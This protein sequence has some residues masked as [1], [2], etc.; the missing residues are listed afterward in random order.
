MAF[1]KKVSKIERCSGLSDKEFYNKYVKKSVPVVVTD[2]ATWA[3][4]EKFTPKFFK[5]NYG[6]LKRTIDGKTY[7]LSEIIDLCMASTPENKAPYPNI[8]DLNQ[9]F[10]EFV[11]EIP[12]I[13]Y[14]KSNRL[15]SPLLLNTFAKR[16][17]QRQLFFGGK[18]CSFPTLHIDYLGVHTQ[19]TQIIGEKDFILY[20]PDQTPY[21]YPD[22]I[23]RN[24]SPVNI[25]DPD[26]D[27]FPLFKNAEPLKTTLKPKETLFIPSG[28]WHTTYIHNFNLTYAIDHVNSFNWNTF[29]DEIYLSAKQKHPKLAW[30]VKGYKV[31]LGKTFDV[32]EALLN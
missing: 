7:T 22:K 10:P 17:N 13:V 1:Q 32:K 29:M 21:F 26:Y 16:T 5:A 23:L 14:G 9:D 11:D 30:I 2:K 3:S 25:M 24:Q 8:F 4:S 20:S 6:H 19:L 31:V 12:L 18:G 28:W 15:F 27:K